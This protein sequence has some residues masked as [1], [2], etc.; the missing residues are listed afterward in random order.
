MGFLRS[1]EEKKLLSALAQHGASGPWASALDAWQAFKDYGRSV[2]LAGGTGL[3]F[4]VGTYDFEGRPLFYFDPVCQFEIVASD[5]EH[6]GFEQ[7]HCELS[8][9]PGPELE[10][11]QA[12]LWSFKY[13]DADSFYAAVEALPEFQAAVRQGNY[14]LRVSY[15]SV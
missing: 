5:G 13:T 1:P 12:N 4:Q 2:S 15:E 14:R 8:C 3:L 10:N 9:L 6:E 11:L 7:L